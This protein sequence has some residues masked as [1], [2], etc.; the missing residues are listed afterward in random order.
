MKSRENLLSKMWRKLRGKNPQPVKLEPLKKPEPAAKKPH[1]TLEPLEGR[2]APAT[3]LNGSTLIFNDIDGDLVTVKFSK[4]VFDPKSPTLATDLAN[5]FQ[6]AP[7]ANGTQQLQLIDL[8]SAPVVG[9]KNT[10]M[11][12]AITITAAK[13]NGNGNDLTNV[14][15][16]K[17]TGLALGA[18]TIDGDLGQIDA[19][20]N[21]RAIAVASLSAR[22]LGVAAGTQ[23]GTADYEST[24]IG[25]LGS[26][27]IATDLAGYVHVV[28]GQPV[29]NT[30]IA[31][32]KIGSATVGG[33][34]VGSA[35]ST[36]TD[37]GTIEADGNIGTVKIGTLASDGLHGGGGSISGSVISLFG[38]IGS[39]AVSGD[40]S[41]GPAVNSAIIYAGGT[42]GTVKVGGSLLGN[43]QIGSGTIRAGGNVT[44][45]TIAHEV[46]GGAGPGTGSV[47]VGGNLQM[48]SIGTSAA[49]H[50][51]G[52]TGDTSGTVVVDGSIGTA[53]VAG[54]IIGVG[55]NS[56]G[57]SA[58][59]TF[60]S[61]T[62]GGNVS[63]GAN[64]DGSSDY[65]G[66][67]ESFSG[68]GTVKVKGNVTGGGGYKSGI[69]V[70]AAKIASV[71]V[72]G[73]LQGGSGDN[74]GSIFGGADPFAARDVGT[75]KVGL[76]LVGGAGN[77]SGS[78]IVDGSIG[79]VTI[80]SPILGPIAMQGS[81][82]E[83]S[84]SISVGDKISTIKITGDVR[85]GAGD[86]SG[87]I[88]GN[89]S[90][91]SLMI[92][93]GLFG[94]GGE[95]SGSILTHNGGNLGTIAISGDLKFGAGLR[96]GSVQSDGSITSLKID[97]S[98]DGGAVRA[99][100][101]IGSLAVKG[102]IFDAVI[103]ARGQ[104]V[105]G[106]TTDLAIGSLTVGGA[107]EQTN[108]FAGYDLDGNAVNPDAQI[109]AVKV[110]LDWIAS[111]LVAGVQ[112]STGHFGDGNDSII[113]SDDDHSQIIS[114]IASVTIGG[115]VKG[116]PDSASSTDHFGF[117]AQQ[118]LAMKVGGKVL[119]LSKT[120]DGEVI[121]FDRTSPTDI[122]PDVSAREI[123][124][125]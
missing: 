5:V 33:S 109:G 67:V 92:K 95:S 60:G 78:I 113:P 26:L 71:E 77:N 125:P 56:G 119:P 93:G 54:S 51:K 83:H 6:F 10:A 1:S 15:A 74:S 99:A 84:G 24:I 123:A 124:T 61:I 66:F 3:L 120:V 70:S 41:G 31:A 19:G 88:E 43:S 53:K 50:L 104:L 18:V 72:S 25:G 122:N 91:A 108:V 107:V 30:L 94:A 4:A 14:G 69:V 98:I 8:T 47:K 111:N 37:I 63:G 102:S 62:V 16:I 44:S 82:G 85:G 38:N 112:S 116:T 118:I 17:A 121:T 64:T 65:S 96:A 22:S 48:I 114:R 89:T 90:I 13:S 2:I 57:I 105:Q 9:G 46:L 81:T 68:F 39:V 115:A 7:G 103:S 106:A 21:S 117:V 28:D 40:V 32:G 45:V 101:A 35:N 11:D 34:L 76:G 49:D 23:S 52:G 79:T 27:K 55:T 42:I 59:G 80:G 20:T 110:T 87:A 12:T 73:K 58:G 29:L 75:V 36:G 86:F 100:D 97:G